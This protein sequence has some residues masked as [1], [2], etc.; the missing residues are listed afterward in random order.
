MTEG[1]ENR[2]VGFGLVHHGPDVVDEHWRAVQLQSFRM[3]RLAVTAPVEGDH[4]EMT[5]QV[6]DLHF[7][8]AGIP[9]GRGR[10]QHHSGPFVFVDLVKDRDTITIEVSLAVGVAAS[11]AANLSMKPRS[12]RLT[13]T[14]SRAGVR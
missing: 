6:G 7:P 11:H 8:L 3:A 2:L 5:G 10:D 13:L 14:G 12:A 1:D 9:D 4:P